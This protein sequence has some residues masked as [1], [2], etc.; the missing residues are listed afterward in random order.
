[1]YGGIFEDLALLDLLLGEDEDGE[2]REEVGGDESLAEVGDAD[3]DAD[4]FLLF[5]R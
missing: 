2:G 4:V 3:P 1:M 5:A